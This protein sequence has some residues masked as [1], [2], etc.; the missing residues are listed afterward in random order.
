MSQSSEPVYVLSRFWKNE[1]QLQR[2]LHLLCAIT[3]GIAAAL[4]CY[5]ARTLPMY[6]PGPGDFNWALDTATALMQ[7][8]DPYAFEP[9][10]LKV[11]YPLPVALFGAPFIALPKPLAA[12]IFF[13]ASSGLLAYGILRSGEPWRLAVFASFPYIYAL[14][15]AQW[16]PL[17]AASWFFPAL[18]PLLVLV[19]PKIALPVALNRLT[20]RGVAF[21]GGVLLVSLLIYPS[22]PWRWLEMTGEYARIVPIL[23]LPFGPVLTLALVRWRDE[24]AW[25]LAAMSALPF[26]GVYDLV[27][28][29]LVPRSLHQ[30][31]LLVMLSWS[32]P[33]FD[34]GIGLQVRPAWSVPLLFLPALVFLLYDAQRERRNRAHSDAQQ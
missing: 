26:R 29:W 17:I 13:G 12:A 32:V 30:A 5:R 3:I 31:F 16:S 14:L 23:T 10:S 11:P 24:R 4:L 6:Y 2:A 28:L 9:S 33:L 8:K 21:A 15:F 18:A 20:R 19:K 1:K 7:G 27:A 22:W 34:F 25:L